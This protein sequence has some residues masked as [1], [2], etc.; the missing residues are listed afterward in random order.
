MNYIVDRKY[1]GYSDNN[2]INLMETSGA[3]CEAATIFL[4]FK[5][6]TLLL[7]GVL[8]TFKSL[9]QA[10]A[11]GDKSKRQQRI[12]ARNECLK[13]FNL[14]A[15]GVNDIANG[16]AAIIEL[17]L[18]PSRPE[19]VADRELGQTQIKTITYDVETNMVKLIFK[20]ADNA[21]S[22]R[23]D[24]SMDNNVWT[25]GYQFATKPNWEFEAPPGPGTIYFRV[26]P[27]DANGKSG[28]ASIAKFV[29]VY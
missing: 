22:Y 9:Y 18:M 7:L 14:M 27:R 28:T 25:E 11:S 15:D 12:K 16:D 13:Y 21:Y 5:P 23:I 8:P 20:K 26:V 29:K 3:A 2:L 4:P 10:T 19:K 1:Q 17:A 24:Y 6:T